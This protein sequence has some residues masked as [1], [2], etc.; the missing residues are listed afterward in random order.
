MTRLWR[1]VLTCALNDEIT[2]AHDWRSRRGSARSPMFQKAFWLLCSWIDPMSIKCAPTVWA[3]LLV[4]VSSASAFAQITPLPRRHDLGA[5]VDDGRHRDSAVKP[6]GAPR[7]MPRPYTALEVGAQLRRLRRRISIKLDPST[8]PKAPSS[9]FGPFFAES[10]TLREAMSSLASF[11]PP[12]RPP[13]VLDVAASFALCRGRIGDGRALGHRTLHSPRT[14]PHLWQDG[15]YGQSRCR[16]HPAGVTVK[17]VA[18]VARERQRDLILFASGTHASSGLGDAAGI[19]KYRFRSFG[20]ALPDPG[21]LAVMAT[22]RLLTGDRE[23][24]RA[25]YYPH[26]RP[27]HRVQRTAPRPYGNVGRILSSGV[28]ALGLR[29]NATVTARH[30]M[31]YAV[32]SST[33]PHRRSPC[34]STC[35]GNRSLAVA[36]LMWRPTRRFL[37][38]SCRPSPSSRCRTEFRPC[39]W[40]RV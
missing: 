2:H 33:R 27:I 9:T 24:L 36:R 22:V 4:L 11:C 17:L 25:G 10:V 1:E 31:T 28:G 5:R 35:W 12:V 26:T 3:A 14:P 8:G 38:V 20:I 7:G 23:S 34:S 19:V 13:R 16:R 37:P 6:V 40:R 30:Q 39:R 32:D 18:L 29:P 21:G 15:R